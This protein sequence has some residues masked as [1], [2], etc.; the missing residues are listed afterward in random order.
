MRSGIHG[1]LALFSFNYGNWPQWGKQDVCDLIDGDKQ[2][3]EYHAPF[4]A[5]NLKIK[6]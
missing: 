5:L 3:E 2:Y 4:Y 1:I 6:L